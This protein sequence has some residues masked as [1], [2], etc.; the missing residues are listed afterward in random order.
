LVIQDLATNRDRSRPTATPDKFRTVEFI[1]QEEMDR[2][3]GYWWSPDEHY[4]ALQS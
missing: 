4:I 1:A 2:D 3:T